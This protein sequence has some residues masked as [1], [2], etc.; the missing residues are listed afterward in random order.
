MKTTCPRARSSIPGTTRWVSNSGAV[1]L[2]STIEVSSSRV[3][4]VNAAAD[5]TPV[6]LTRPSSGPSAA[7]L[8]SISELV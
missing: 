4:S 6:L 8:R 1:R 7:S 2:R 3:Y 5:S